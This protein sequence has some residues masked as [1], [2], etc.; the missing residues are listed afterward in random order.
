MCCIKAVDRG[1][2]SRSL[3]KAG[4]GLVGGQRVRF[5]GEEGQDG[6]K[7][8]LPQHQHC[9]HRG[10]SSAATTTTVTTATTMIQ[11]GTQHH[12]RESRDLFRA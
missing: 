1:P 2:R 6:L 10:T 11:T 4:L 7:R 12:Q 5:L 8:K 3:K 9:H